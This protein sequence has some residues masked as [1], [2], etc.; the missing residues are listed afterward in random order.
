MEQI[1]KGRA[2]W[3]KLFEPSNFFQRYSH[4]I[5]LICKSA[6]EKQHLE[7]F[8][9]ITFDSVLS[10]FRETLLLASFCR[11]GLVESKLRLLIHAFEAN[12]YIQLIHVCPT[13]FGPRDPDAE[14]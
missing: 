3:A 10:S 13:R 4:F 2:Q 12:I 14:R 8:A 6:S 9:Q 11:F 7:W 1:L 5:V